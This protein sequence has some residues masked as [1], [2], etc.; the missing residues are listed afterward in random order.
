MIEGDFVPGVVA[1]K[2][3][4]KPQTGYDVFPFPAVGDSGNAVVGGGDSI[5]MFNDTPAAQA[6]VKYLAEPGG[7]EDLG[8]A[9]RVL[10]AEQERRRRAPTRTTSRARRR[11][12]SPRP[13]RSASTCPTW[14]RPRSAAPPARASGRS[15]RTSWP[16]RPTSTRPPASS[17]PAAGEGVQVSRRAQPPAI[18]RGVAP[19]SRR[20][21]A[22]P[23]HARSSSA[24]RCSSSG[25]WIVYPTIRTIIRSF[26]DRDGST[27]RLV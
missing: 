24:R 5:A 16:S 14:R 20:R 8:Q 18:A 1:S 17:R 27:L 11:P 25:V 7:G 3:T 23:S 2:T 13:T 19:P 9:R 21:R 4:L 10:L 26:F 15:C 6:L 12:R 22:A